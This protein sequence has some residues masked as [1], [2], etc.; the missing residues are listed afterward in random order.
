[1]KQT[2]VFIFD[3]SPATGLGNQVVEILSLNEKSEIEVHYK[4]LQCHPENTDD[5]AG[6]LA[7]KLDAKV[8]DSHLVI[9][10]LILPAVFCKECERLVLA[11]KNTFAAEQIIVV[12][13]TS[14]PDQ[15]LS[16]LKT[17]IASCITPPIKACNVLPGVWRLLEFLGEK[18]STV[19]HLKSRLGMGQF[20]GESHR[21]CSVIENI[22][23][24]ARCAANVLITGESG[25]GK[26]MYARAIHYLGLRQRHPFVAINCGAIP[27]ELIENEL[28][29]HVRGA[30]TG[31]EN[32]QIGLIQEAEG[33]T[34]FLDEIDS[35]PLTAQVKLLRVLQEKEYRLLGSVKT[36]KVDVRFVA[37][38]NVDADEA[39]KTGKIRQ[40]LYYRLN[41][42]PVHLPSLRERRE[43]IP[44]LARHF[45]KKYSDEFGK[46]QMS[47]SAEA[48]IRLSAY[49]WPGNV[50]EL[51]NQIE[52]AVA[53]GA[54]TVIQ[55]ADLCLPGGDERKSHT[56]AFRIAKEKYV[57]QFERDYIRDLLCT[58]DGNVTRAAQAAEKNRRAF[59]ELMR[60]YD[61]DARDF[62]TANQPR[63]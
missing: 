58:Y 5:V 40:D 18:D 7:N 54:G 61:I 60:K 6:A 1:M 22:P 36:H 17:G 11:M 56:G 29:G 57:E 13:D 25:T 9:A 46:S 31:A 16:A 44:L 14:D 2:A 62:K 8:N 49:D 39:V 48:V 32:S 30:Y 35:L 28:F 52:R 50:R 63:H 55:A 42:I 37:A 4:N 43:D 19:Q 34:L 20:I 59:W 24:I 51:E 10:F 21:F 38:T 23:M 27:Q 45:L 47:L 53:L 12:A 26:E 33:G 41:V 15:V 3:F